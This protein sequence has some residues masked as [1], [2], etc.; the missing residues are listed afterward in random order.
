M[1]EGQIQDIAGKYHVD[2][3]VL[4]GIH[5][6]AGSTGGLSKRTAASLGADLSDPVSAME[7]SAKY[8]SILLDNNDGDYKKSLQQYHNS[9]H[10]SGSKEDFSDRVLQY[11]DSETTTADPRPSEADTDRN[12]IG[13]IIVLI[14]VILCF[15]GAFLC[16]M[17]SFGVHPQDKI[18]EAGK[19]LAE[20]VS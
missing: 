2:A 9:S 19:I 11:E 4:K 16:I 7:G 5:A 14:L 6:T 10:M 17:K 8:L 13:K 3:S 1:T 12:I 18:E 20:I 15:I